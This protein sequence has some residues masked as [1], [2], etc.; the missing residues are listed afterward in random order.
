MKKILSKI[1]FI[2]LSLPLLVSAQSLNFGN[3]FTISSGADGYGRPR[4]ALTNDQPII[5][6]GNP[7]KEIDI[8]DVSDVIDANLKALKYDLGFRTFNIST[9]KVVRVIDIAEK[10]KEVTNRINHKIIFEKQYLLPDEPDM[11]SLSS[12]VSQSELKISPKKNIEDMIEE[13]Y[14]VIRNH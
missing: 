7:E 14:K 11:S 9:N 13:T 12:Y 6:K 2:T 8:I 1:I 10:V 5:I 4:I 3:T